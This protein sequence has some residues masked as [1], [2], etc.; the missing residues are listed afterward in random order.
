MPLSSDH[1]II[2][3]RF[4]RA[5][6]HLSVKPYNKVWWNIS[7]VLNNK[8]R[9][10]FSRKLIVALLLLLAGTSAGLFEALHFK[11]SPAT[12][13]TAAIVAVQL[14]KKNN[15]ELK[16]IPPSQKQVVAKEI[17]SNTAIA[18]PDASRTLTLAPRVTEQNALQG[19]ETAYLPGIDSMTKMNTLPE[20]IA[21][22]NFVAAIKKNSELFPVLHTSPRTNWYYLG[23]T[24][25][26]NNTYIVDAKAIKSNSLS[27]ES[28]FGISY[29][30]QAGYIFS[31]HWGME[32]AWLL[33]SWEGQNYRNA[34]LYGR[35]TDLNYTEKSIALTYS[36]V[37]L[38]VQYKVPKFSGLLNTPV[39]FNLTFGG[40]Y[41][42]LIAFRM[43]NEKEDVQS[44]ELFRRSEIAGVLGFDYDFFVTKPVFYS[45]GLRGSYSSNIFKANAPDYLDFKTPHN[46][47]IGFHAAVN[48][49]LKRQ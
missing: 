44:N 17:S 8:Q 11:Q 22:K 48:F 26:F 19:Y 20:M 40:E 7:S 18:G 37:P 23:F 41:G 47:L 15:L 29:G 3:D 28:T 5:L 32:V 25:S 45:L 10:I 16:I 2:D 4:K 6:H 1:H 12:V 33:N 21:E 27:Y 46:L 9:S 13:V 31:K 14:K 49:S 39:N 43:D 34:N 24:S 35:T 38:L 36:Q 30:I 42:R